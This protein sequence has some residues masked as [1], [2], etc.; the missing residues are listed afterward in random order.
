MYLE[1]RDEHLRFGDRW[2]K[3]WAVVG[4]AHQIVCCR[5]MEAIVK[6]P[7]VAIRDKG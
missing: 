7:A 1:N 6:G 2:A 3:E 5:Q 4:A